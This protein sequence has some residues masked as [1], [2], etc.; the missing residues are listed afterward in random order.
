MNPLLLNFPDSFES[1]RLL[2]RA[3]RPGDGAPMNAA[4]RESIDEL[5][6]WMPWAQSVPT[7]E[8]SEENVRRAI[9]KFITREDLRLHAF[10]KQ[11]GDFIVGT[12]LHRI[13]WTVPSFEIGYWVRTSRTGCGYVTEAV[14]AVTR[15]AFDA[16]SA[17][18]VE[19]R[20]DP[21]NLRSAR[22]AE[23]CGFHLEATLRHNDRNTSGELCD[24]HVYAM[25]RAE[26]LA[27]R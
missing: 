11:T 10:D 5:R 14:T 27:R 9:A 7:I 16:L 6:P 13:N 20:C 15:F 12:G 22:V 25:L 21:K 8:D 2:I 1:E 4:V 23:R 17:E 3:P 18:R 19:I 24:T 26:Y